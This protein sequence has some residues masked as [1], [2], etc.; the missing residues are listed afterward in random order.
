MKL[1]KPH[2]E[3]VVPSSA[4]GTKITV[5]RKDAP[6][7]DWEGTLLAHQSKVAAADAE[8]RRCRDALYAVVIEATNDSGTTIDSIA[9]AAGWSVSYLRAM[10]GKSADAV[11]RVKTPSAKPVSPSVAKRITSARSALEKAE[12]K[13]RSSRSSLIGQIQRVT[14]PS[15][16]MSDV[17][18]VLGVSRQRVS[19]LLDEL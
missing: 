3:A 19:Q 17:A 18:E 4:D 7:K 1:R 12:E 15:P 9:E 2:K 14:T 5:V 16:T 10:R 6:L 13:Y 8:V 11:T